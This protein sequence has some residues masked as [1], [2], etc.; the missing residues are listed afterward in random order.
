MEIKQFKTVHEPATIRNGASLGFKCLG[1]QAFGKCKI[2]NANEACTFDANGVKSDDELCSRLSLKNTIPERCLVTVTDLTEA[3]TGDWSC[4]LD[5]VTSQP[6]LLTVNPEL[7]VTSASS[8]VEGQKIP[9]GQ[10]VDLSCSSNE[11]IATCAFQDTNG[12]TCTAGEEACVDFDGRMTATII[13]STTCTATLETVADENEFTCTLGSA[14]DGLE[15]SA[16]L[17][18]FDI[19]PKF[20]VTIDGGLIEGEQKTEGDKITLTCEG[21]H[22]VETC[23]FDDIVNGE[24]AASL[25]NG[26]TCQIEIELK[27]DHEGSQITCNLTEHGGEMATAEIELSVKSTTTTT[28]TTTTTPPGI[29]IIL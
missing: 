7:S 26:K 4:E 6:K 8:A 16:T 27:V 2:Q 1:N 29:I 24:Q 23:T 25:V 14:R 19:K 17:P 18:Q 9:E 21:N 11:E 13:D 12:N 28:T 22:E 10:N 3:D 20:T 5:N 15:K